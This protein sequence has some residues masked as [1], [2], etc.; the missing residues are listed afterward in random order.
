MELVTCQDFVRLHLRLLEME[1]RQQRE[2]QRQQASG[3]LLSSVAVT[4]ASRTFCGQRLV[5]RSTGPRARKLPRHSIRAND[6][7]ITRRASDSVVARRTAGR[8]ASREPVPGDVWCGVVSRVTKAELTL[9]FGEVT[10]LVVGEPVSVMRT[11]DEMTHKNMVK[12]LEELAEAKGGPILRMRA[13]LFA[14]HGPP[15]TGKTA[16]VV[17]VILQHQRL[18]QRVLVCAASHNAVD[19]VLDR[20]EAAR[21]E[22]MV[23]VA[24]ETVK[25][26]DVSDDDDDDDDGDASE[27]FPT[28]GKAPFDLVVIEECSQALEAACWLAAPLAN[29]LLLAGDHSQLPPMVLS[30]EAAEKGLAVSLMERQMAL[31]G[32]AVVRMLRTQYRM[33]EHIQRWPS[34]AMYGSLLEAAPAVCRH[35]LSQLP[36]VRD[37]TETGPVL[38]VVDTA[39]CRLEET[40][41]SKMGSIA[42]EGE[43]DIVVAHARALLRAGLDIGQLGVISPYKR[44]LDLVRARLR[45]LRLDVAVGTVD[46]FQGREKEAVLLSLVRSNQRGQ[47]GFLAERRRI[48]VAVTRARRQLFVV[49]DTAT[50]RS[51]AFLASLV[52]HLV[53]HGEVRSAHAYRNYLGVAA[54]GRWRWLDATEAGEP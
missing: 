53:E 13:A 32:A 40:P 41:D 30:R 47:V 25:D 18:G 48:N 44:Q 12:A 51:D 26:I 8:T 29:K 27:H 1:H 17:E 9:D 19:N 50:V 38:L 34:E 3:N 7:V 39:G 24:V 21:G 6:H 36:G 5:L 45:Q 37:T 11:D 49:C 35:R 43:A 16:T 42:N 31:H 15:G 54:R 2:R 20:L 23:R 4:A 52:D 28:D 46:G 14:E 22:R 33:H 10:S